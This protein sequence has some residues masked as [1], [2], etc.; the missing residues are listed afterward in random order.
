MV[1]F[2]HH[3]R[4]AISFLAS[5]HRPTTK[6]AAAFPTS[7]GAAPG[8]T[9]CS[10][11]RFGVVLRVPVL[12]RVSWI[13]PVPDFWTA[14][15]WPHIKSWDRWPLLEQPVRGQPFPHAWRSLCAHPSRERRPIQASAVSG[16]WSLEGNAS[17]QASSRS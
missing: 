9:G 3:P 14:L 7:C 12:P 5:H 6:E 13:S 15:L 17:D 11:G 4:G 10:G 8:P 1:A 16:D 2:P